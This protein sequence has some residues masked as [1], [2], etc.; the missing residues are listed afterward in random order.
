MKQKKQS[1]GVTVVVIVILLLLTGLTG[2]NFF[3][4]PILKKF[5][6]DFERQ[7]MAQEQQEAE[8]NKLPVDI[9]SEALTTLSTEEKIYQLIALPVT[10]NDVEKAPNLS[11]IKKTNPG[12]VTI[13]GKNIDQKQAKKFISTVQSQVPT[14]LLGKE[15]KQL[16]PLAA[17]DHEGGVVQRLSGEGFSI[18]PAWE[19]LCEVE[20]EER[21]SI[22]AISAAEL[23]ETGINVV[24]AP[25]LDV[26]YGNSF[27]KTR[28]CGNEA[29]AIAA[30]RSYILEFGKQQIFSVTKHFP[31]LGTVA[32]DI[33]FREA[34]VSPSQS[35]TR[36]FELMLKTFPNIGVMT[37]HVQVE[38]VT[39]GIPCSLSNVCLK[40]FPEVFPQALLFTDALE[41]EAALSEGEREQEKLMENNITAAIPEDTLPSALALV[42]Y[43]ALLAGN[44]V[45]VYGQD[46]S[47]EDL[48]EVVQYLA[49]MAEEDRY[50]LGIIEQSA[51]KTLEI[52]IGQ[53][54]E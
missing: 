10:L 51:K 44:N 22:L 18:L 26:N 39:N 3:K 33:H 52:K 43:K 4:R 1:Y 27:L 35:D 11:W 20:Q 21:E 42:S 16:V 15:E 50:L 12:Y 2:Y 13:F 5:L 25:V 54:G 6:A 37:T 29:R 23:S 36:P 28:A 31:G 9:V 34:V 40:E 24:F 17:V 30:A 32:K 14:T 45:L 49:S 41:M 53:A 47:Q 19:E 46:V 48:E 38:G 7:R 8:A